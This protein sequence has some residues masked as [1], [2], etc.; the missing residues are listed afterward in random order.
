MILDLHMP[1]TESVDA[2]TPAHVNPMLW[3][4]SMGLARQIAARVFRDN[5]TPSDAVSVVGLSAPSLLTWDKAVER[6]AEHLSASTARTPRAE[7]V[8]RRRAA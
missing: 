2:E 3:Q 1:R 6:I 8:F 7:T 5:G 4:Q